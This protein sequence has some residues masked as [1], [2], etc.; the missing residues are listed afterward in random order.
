M[1]SMKTWGVIILLLVVIGGG[2]T[3]YYFYSR[4]KIPEFELVDIGLAKEA[5]VVD[6]VTGKAFT[7]PMPS[8]DTEEKEKQYKKPDPVL[9]KK[10]ALV[11]LNNF[12]QVPVGSLLQMMLRGSWLVVLDGNGEFV[13]EDARG[14]QDGKTKIVFWKLLQGQ[15]RAVPYTALGGNQW[16]VVR[17]PHV[18]LIAHQAEFGVAV[19]RNGKGSAFVMSGKVTALWDDGRRKVLGL[20]GAE[21]L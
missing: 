8:E 1:R 14:S 3:G 4:D 7:W 5:G 16:M 10:G 6:E 21:S 20:K 11:F 2:A 12:F 15:L 17:T 9:L 19:D 13:L 18:K